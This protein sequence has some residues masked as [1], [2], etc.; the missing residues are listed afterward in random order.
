MK[1][2]I[3]TITIATVTLSIAGC[4]EPAGK[5]SLAS[6]EPTAAQR[7]VEFHSLTLQKDGTFYAEAREGAGIESVSGTYYMDN[8]VLVLT[9]HDGEVHGYD[10]RFRDGG[11]ELHLANFQDGQKVKLKY[12]LRERARVVPD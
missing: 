3:W 6:V 7:D 1:T 10:A 9:E 4:H 11:K 12:D 2:K 5:W 8:G